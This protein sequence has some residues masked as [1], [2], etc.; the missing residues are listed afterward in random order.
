MVF[1]KISD[2]IN[3]EHTKLLIV[4]VVF[5]IAFVALLEYSTINGKNVIDILVG[6]LK[7]VFN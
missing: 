7:N 1:E 5:L 6:F 2:F 3:R 4:I